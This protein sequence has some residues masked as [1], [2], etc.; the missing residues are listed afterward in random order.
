[1]SDLDF[2]QNSGLYDPDDVNAE[3]VRGLLFWL[4]DL[5]WEPERIVAQAEDRD[6]ALLASESSLRPVPEFTLPQAADLVGLSVEDLDALRR[7]AGLAPR[8]FDRP[9]FNKAEMEAFRGL[10]QGSEM[11]TMEEANHFARVLGSSLAKIAEAAVS[12]FLIDVEGPLRESGGTDLELATQNLRATN[13]LEGLTTALD[14]LLRLHLDDAIRRSREARHP[15][16]DVHITR[17]AVGFVDLVGFTAFSQNVSAAELGL[18]VRRFEDAAYDLAADNDGRVVKLIGD[19]VMFVAVN[20]EA[21]C[22]IAIA[23]IGQFREDHVTPRG[24]LAYGEL[25][26]RS[27]DYYG[28]IVNLASRIGDLAVP[29]ELLATTEIAE[30]CPAYDFEPAGRRQ[31]KGFREPISLVSLSC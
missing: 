9:A 30:A 25:L 26:A 21:A 12:L 23:M 20:P 16:D 24:G 19:E 7:T 6:L 17:M 15:D 11:F 4:E 10:Q 27:G 2:Y 5:G 14:P 29:C 3:Q 1:M 22:R 8:P 28:P 18:L 31:L 13:A